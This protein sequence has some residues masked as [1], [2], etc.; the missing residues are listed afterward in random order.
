LFINQFKTYNLA[1]NVPSQVFD[2]L[3]REFKFNQLY[4]KFSD[5]WKTKVFVVPKKNST[6]LKWIE[7]CITQSKLFGKT[8][9]LLLPADTEASW[10]RVL[11]KHASEIRFIKDQL[12][13]QNQF[14]YI[15]AIFR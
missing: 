6:K 1:E 13:G 12:S 10:F 9:V 8:C 7:N 11:T 4:P 2:N 3:D 14:A 5:C 15:I